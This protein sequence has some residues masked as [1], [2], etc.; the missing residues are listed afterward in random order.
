MCGIA[1]F[2]NYSGEIAA[3]RKLIYEM[4]SNLAHRGPDGW[5]I[6]ISDKISFGHTRLSIVDLSGGNQ[7]MED[8]RFVISYNGE[9]YNHIELRNELKTLG[10]K[11]VTSSDT[12]VIIKAYT[13]FGEDCFTKFNGQFAILLW[14]K[15]EQKL[16]I[17]R[18]R[19]GVRPLYILHLNGSFYFSSETKSFD[20]IPGFQRSF[21]MINLFTHGLL[22]NTLGDETVFSGIRSLPSGTLEVYRNNELIY[23]RRYYQLGESNGSSPSTLEEAG[24]EFNALLEDA[25]KLRL[26]SDVPVGAYLSGGI[27]SSVT[28]FLAKQFNKEELKTFSVAFEDKDFDES[29][30]QHEMVQQLGS[31]HHEVKMSYKLLDETFADVIYHTERPIFRT[32]PTPL[33]LLS[34]LVSDTNIRVVLTGEGADEIL[35][36][37]DVFKELKMLEFWS[38]QPNS[39]LRPLIIRKL[40]PHLHHYND[41]KQ[42]GMIKMF[43]EGFLDTYK[44]P[45][46]GLNMRTNN[47]RVLE[48]YFNKDYQLKFDLDALVAKVS[49]QMPQNS[50][51]WSLLQKNQFLE[52]RTL[53]SGYLLSSQGDR[54]AMSHGIEGRFP[55]L[56]HRLVERLFYFN[57][58]YK[59]NGFKQKFLLA[60]TYKNNIP[61]SI[62]KRPKLP[63]MA[64]DLKSFVQGGRLTEHTAWFLSEKLIKEYGIFEPGFIKM[65]VNKFEN[66]MPEKPGYRDN[67]LIT[68]ILSAQ[69]AAYWMKNPKKNFLN[70]H[71]KTVDITVS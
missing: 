42:F 8:E 20:V 31:K 71:N 70:E 43:Y 16:I 18:D 68:F 11:F 44:N 38:K 53:L 50:V 47:N 23:N 22:W 52:M 64:P 69:I 12:E 46:L 19:Y 25:V 34:K 59:L 35:W 41:P 27:D 21:D 6:Y 9:I 62:I 30:Y 28:S 63:Y 54:M 2:Y 37:Y 17:A 55:F 67:M 7:P 51:N 60:N 40:Y 33:F 32:A 29:F 14:D 61:S 36:G 24:E 45:L 39:N 65:L 26:R 4:T 56:D 66:R 57:E 48:N 13:Q 10:H 58:K 5:G 49:S 1:G 15:K 3:R